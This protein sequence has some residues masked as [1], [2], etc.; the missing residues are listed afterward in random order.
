MRATLWRF[1]NPQ[2]VYLSI[3]YYTSQSI[4][5]ARPQAQS[6]A[7]EVNHGGEGT[8]R[9]NETEQELIT[10]NEDH[11]FLQELSS[12]GLYLQLAEE[13]KED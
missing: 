3:N 8:G 13:V 10:K 11:Y 6:R 5:L 12:T 9:I 4:V 2:K 1:Q 7:E